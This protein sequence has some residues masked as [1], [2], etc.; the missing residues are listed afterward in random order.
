[1]IA[2]ALKVMYNCLVYFLLKFFVFSNKHL[3][4]PL[5]HMKWFFVKTLVWLRNNFKLNHW[6]L[7]L[8]YKVLSHNVQ[9]VI[10]VLS[11]ALSIFLFLLFCGY[12]QRRGDRRIFLGCSQKKKRR[13]LD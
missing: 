8:Y 7:N 4:V 2:L 3:F 12:I 13:L 9:Y 10:E 11:N 1:M 6:T 5:I